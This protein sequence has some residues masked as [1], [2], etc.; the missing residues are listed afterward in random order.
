MNSYIRI[1]IIIAI[2]FVLHSE[3]PF[4]V[5]DVAHNFKI[6]KIAHLLNSR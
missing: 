3:Q 2:L 1:N 6:Y 4:G 5:K